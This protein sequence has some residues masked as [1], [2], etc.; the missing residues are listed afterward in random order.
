MRSRREVL[1]RGPSADPPGNATIT[2][3]IR[4]RG[5]ASVDRAQRRARPLVRAGFPAFV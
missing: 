3:D 4:C 1:L 5:A 2:R